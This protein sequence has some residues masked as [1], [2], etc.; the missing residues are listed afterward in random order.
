MVSERIK[1]QFTARQL[2]E[3]CQEQTVD[4]YMTFGDHTKAFDTVSC[5]GMWKIMAKF[6]CQARFIAM[7]WQFHVGILARVQNDGKYSKYF[8]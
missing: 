3:K 7:V 1:E 2:Q 8:L 4:L 6:D 5:D